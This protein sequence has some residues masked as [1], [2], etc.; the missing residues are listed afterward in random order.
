MRLVSRTMEE[1]FNNYFDGEVALLTNIFLP[2][3]DATADS[4]RALRRPSTKSG[5]SRKAA[6]AS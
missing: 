3:V 1:M 6:M 2:R 4:V 5:R